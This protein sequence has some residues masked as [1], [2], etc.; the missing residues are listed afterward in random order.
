MSQYGLLEWV[1]LIRLPF[2][3]RGK[4]SLS[5]KKGFTTGHACRIDLPKGMDITLRINENV[6][7]GDNVHIVAHQSVSIGEN[8]LFA[9]KIFISDT[10]HGII[11]GE[12]EHTNPSI[13]PASRPL[14][15]YPVKIGNNVWVGENVVILPGVTIGDGCIIGA[16]SVIN[17]DIPAYT[18]AAG[19][20]AKVIKQYD[21]ETSR[22]VTV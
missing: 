6:R 15:S 8:C 18:I 19:V 22:W 16:N 21:F 3:L 5:L 11:K 20:P 9:S 2:Y 14:I 13:P 7:I 4:K 17:R 10:D 12:G 1:R